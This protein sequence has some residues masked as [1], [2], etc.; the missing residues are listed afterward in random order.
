MRA[1]R[2][3]AR[4]ATR[5]RAVA[6]GAERV[7]G[8]AIV[9]GSPV[10]CLLGAIACAACSRDTPPASE[11]VAEV[12]A[13]VVLAG[14]RPTIAIGHN[15]FCA[16]KADGKVSCWG[17]NES[18]Q[19]GDGTT[20]ASDTPKSSVTNAVSVG[21]GYAHSCAVLVDGTAR[22]WGKND[23]G[24]LGNGTTTGSSTPA[25]VLAKQSP[26]TALGSVRAMGG[27]RAHSCALSGGNAYCWGDNA[28]GQV[29]SGSTAASLPIATLVSD[30]GG[31]AIDL[32]VGK[33][34][35]CLLHANGT[36]ACWGKN[37]VSQLGGATTAAFSAIPV[38]VP[39]ISAAISIRAGAEHTCATLADGTVKC[40]GGNASGQLGR[41][42]T[43]PG[44][45]PDVLKTS[46]GATFGGV[47]STA[48]GEDFGCAL[49][50]GKVYCW[51][52]NDA[53]QLG[54]GGT[55]ATTAVDRAV[56]AVSDAV[57]LAAGDDAACVVAATGAVDCWGVVKSG[58]GKWSEAWT[59][60]HWQA[61]AR[62]VDDRSLGAPSLSVGER[63][64]CTIRAGMVGCWGSNEHGQLG[65]TTT[66]LRTT[67]TPVAELQHAK[68]V[69]VGQ[70]HSCA[71]RADGTVLC[72]GWNSA[73]QLGLGTTSEGVT[74]P[75]LVPGVANAKALAT[76]ANHT[77]AL[78]ANG[79][80]SCWG[81]NS[82]AQA[83]QAG[84][85]VRTSPTPFPGVTNAVAIGA[86]KNHTCAVL[87]SGRVSCWG[88]N[89][90]CQAGPTKSSAQPALAEISGI[91]DAVAVDGGVAHSCALRAN[92]R[93]SCWGSNSN[94]QLSRTAAG[95]ACSAADS[96]YSYAAVGISVGGNQGCLVMPTGSVRCW[97]A[98]GN[99]QL[100]NNSTA[101]TDS[102]EP[103]D[104]TVANGLV[105]AVGDASAC[106]LA[107]D[108]TAKCWG[109]N[110]YGTLGNG[111]SG[112]DVLV[113]TAVQ[114]GGGAVFTRSC[115]A[116]FSACVAASDCCS[117]DCTSGQCQ[118][119]STC[120][121]G[122]GAGDACKNPDRCQR[123]T[124][125]GSGG[126]VVAGAADTNDGNPCTADACSTAA[127]TTH[128]PLSQG[129]SCEDGVACNGAETCNAS[130]VCMM[131]ASS[132]CA[133]QCRN[134]PDGTP[135]ADGN[136]CT[137]TDTCQAGQCVGQNPVAC[138]PAADTCHTAGVCDPATGKCGAAPA[139][140]DGQACDDKNLCTKTDTCA[141]GVCT[142]AGS[143]TCT[144]DACHE[145]G[146]CN[147]ATG[148]CSVG[149][150]KPDGTPLRSR[151]SVFAW[152]LLPGR[153]VHGHGRH[154]R[155]GGRFVPF[156]GHLQPCDRLRAGRRAARWNSV[157]R[158]QLLH[159]GGPLHERRVRGHRFG[160][161]RG[162]LLWG[163]PPEERRRVRS[164][165]SRW[166]SP[167]LLCDLPSDR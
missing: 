32:A 10:Y 66:T 103:V 49:S 37:N 92:G 164:R 165:A 147:P 163:R 11:P 54:V 63:H 26:A 132:A 84:A 83:G 105:V 117:S 136:P 56:S 23:S 46:A 85:G 135:C 167:S 115:G 134:K 140:P 64:A 155:K 65:D 28:Y 144:A 55:A 111:S 59:P 74:K 126:C 131:G 133:D 79:T 100:G 19:L 137:L 143:V 98:N 121:S 142:G 38:A 102:A 109:S 30:T 154:V 31:S 17:A 13:A 116:E 112:G 76:G 4:L 15:H 29:G 158:W 2:K 7:K 67:V 68:S 108:G 25:S 162:R 122:Y 130:G 125:N 40:W 151:Q 61:A 53:G 101:R 150:A 34:H 145:A 114:V 95:D 73:G 18:G 96:A 5:P 45:A 21:A 110:Q 138:A 156:P 107:V 24:Q 33:D 12:T 159:E 3:R 48:G 58:T 93:V 50:A 1:L 80:V 129:A 16:V 99:G 6:Q 52:A 89:G 153:R 51:G 20:M 47:L 91:S 141:A 104:T 42:A 123:S 152:R 78:L 128:T 86:G 148:A 157:R 113:P 146:A 44:G 120:P 88:A 90:N 106:A 82:S 69:S 149:A 118:P 27:G 9:R 81:D 124:C 160:G 57:E 71:I 97:G 41:G 119:L 43:S 14:A 127:G 39:L 166:G 75:T 87:A 35:A 161:S 94:K 62:N 72:W 36:V 77:C 8:R 139:K 60:T 22:C 70:Y